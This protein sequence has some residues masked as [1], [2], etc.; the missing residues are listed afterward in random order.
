MSSTEDYLIFNYKLKISNYMPNMAEKRGRET[1]ILYWDL[2]ES[3][4]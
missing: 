2:A 3:H 1:G 4:F